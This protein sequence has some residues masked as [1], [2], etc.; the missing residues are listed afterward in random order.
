[1]MSP[2]GETASLYLD[3][4]SLRLNVEMH[5]S[6]EQASNAIETL[7]VCAAGDGAARPVEEEQEERGRPSDDPFG[8]RGIWAKTRNRFLGSRAARTSGGRTMGSAS[9]TLADF[10]TD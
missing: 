6:L 8:F 5:G 10:R 4:N 1:M 2:G 9:S 7:K 3:G